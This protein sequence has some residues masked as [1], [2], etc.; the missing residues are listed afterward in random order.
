MVQPFRMRSEESKSSVLPAW[1]LGFR[2]VQM[3]KPVNTVEIY[4]WNLFG[5]VNSEPQ[6][7]LG[8]SFLAPI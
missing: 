7:A 2:S 1:R 6:A 3:V 4:I 8:L 5:A